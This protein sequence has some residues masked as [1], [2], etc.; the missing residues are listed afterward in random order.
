MP[1]SSWLDS[2]P[3]ENHSSIQCETVLAKFVSLGKRAARRKSGSGFCKPK[4]APEWTLAILPGRDTGHALDIQQLP[5][6]VA[7]SAVDR[8]GNASHP[9]VL[10]VQQQSVS[11]K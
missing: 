10:E 7:V 4:S 1:S 9:S 11:R 6:F 2:V 8:C 5:R 3:P